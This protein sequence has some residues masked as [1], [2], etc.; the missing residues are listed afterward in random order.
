MST[1][2]AYDRIQK[3]LPNGKTTT[4]LGELSIGKGVRSLL[5]SDNTSI[6]P[7]VIIS[8]K[9]YVDGIE[10]S[11]TVYRG[12]NMGQW[13]DDAVDVNVFTLGALDRTSVVCRF[14][15]RIDEAR[16]YNKGLT[17]SEVTSLYNNPDGQGSSKT[18]IYGYDDYSRTNF[19]QL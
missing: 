1:A 4:Y 2:L 3:I 10:K 9:L 14:Q 6:P 11:L 17:Q 12:G 18:T 13:F 8:T 16:T 5:T 19:C 7:S 15:G